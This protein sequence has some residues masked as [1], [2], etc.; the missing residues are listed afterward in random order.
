ME[1]AVSICVPMYN[2]APYLAQCLESAL[3]QTC[4]DIEIVLVDDQSTDNT[5]AIA[6]DFVRRDPR[7]RLYRNPKNLGLVANWCKSVELANGEWIK[8][9]FQDDILAPEC[10]TRMLDSTRPDV[11]LVAVR[12]SVIYQEGTPVSV[13]EM[14][15]KY[16]SDHNLTNLF[17]DCSY[18]SPREFATALIQAP[19]G[20]CIGEPTATLIRKSAFTK[21]GYFNPH[22]I[23][24]C[25]WEYFARVAVNTG[26][27]YINQPLAFF[28]VHSQARSAEIRNH[29][30]SCTIDSLIIQ[31]EMAYSGRY[32]I[33]RSVAEKENPPI[34]LKYR[35]AEAVRRARW[36]ALNMNDGGQ[37]MAEWWRAIIS[38]P[39]LLLFPLTYVVNLGLQ[40]F[41]R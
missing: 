22:L 16:L 40:K 38:Y 5:I 26:L 13:K 23:S 7:I 35:L 3:S 9:V 20:N 36:E 33:V 10:I 4:T 12:R 41:H 19:N 28:R 8:F 11:D 32:T 18:I 37:A 21:Y 6:E 15:E 39:R 30:S 31:H 14:Y 2:G 25:D 17:F 34:R 29:R 24:L 1:P 27:C